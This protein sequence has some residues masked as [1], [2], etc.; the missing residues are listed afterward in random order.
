MNDETA[1]LNQIKEIINAINL[2]SPTP[3]SIV[4]LALLLAIIV[5][6]KM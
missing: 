6:V 3:L 1:T 2:L 5:A 4:G